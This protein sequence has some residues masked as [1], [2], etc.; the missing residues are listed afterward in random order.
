MNR[1]GL[2]IYISLDSYVERVFGAKFDR[3]KFCFFIIESCNNYQTH[4]VRKK[5]LT[6][7]KN[8]KV[9]NKNNLI[10]VTIARTRTT[11]KIV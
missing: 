3:L 11:K 4:S 10:L 8:N 6:L 7:N 1:N 2:Y 5:N 9:N